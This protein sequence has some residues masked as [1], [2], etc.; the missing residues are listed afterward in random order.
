MTEHVVVTDHQGVRTIR[1]NRPDKKN[2][3]TF[4]M[5]GAMTRALRQGEADPAIRVH[6]LAGL[7]GCFTA[8]N[9]LG[10]FLTAG[11]V[12]SSPAAE[13]L[14]VLS[15]A[16]KP[17]V[18]AVGGLAIGIGVTMLLHCDLVYAA[19]DAVLQLPFI[20][21]ALVPEGGSSLLLPKLMGHQ[22]AAELLMLG[23]PFDAATAHGLGLVNALY[24]MAE[25]ERTAADRAA[26][27][28]AKPAQALAATKA[29]LR[30]A[31]DTVSHRLGVEFTAFGR[32]LRSAELR[33]AVAAFQEK[34]PPNFHPA[35]SQG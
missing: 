6:L 12:A 19:E 29:L 24:P 4:A 7:P 28:A 2:A 15:A 32:A 31:E 14:R 30:L 25:L 17:V 27:L 22:R 18:V 5:Y 34:R 35:P 3:I 8:G 16:A 13:F 10:D 21:L 26:V 9:D 20:N 11:D 1:M 23:E 33:E